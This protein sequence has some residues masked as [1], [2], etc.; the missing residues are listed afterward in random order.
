MSR[1]AAPYELDRF[2]DWNG[3]SAVAQRSQNR[4]E[5]HVQFLAHVFGKEAQHQVAAL[6]QQLILATVATIRD[7]IRKMLGAIQLH[8]HTRISTVEVHFQLSEAIKRDRQR[9]VDAE[10]SLGL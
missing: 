10:T 4:I 3:R 6:L 8:R 2:S 7:R 5:Y 1:P 9:H